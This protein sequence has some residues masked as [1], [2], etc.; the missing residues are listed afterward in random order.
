[1]SG[2]VAR[3]APVRPEPS[4]AAM[5]DA[6]RCAAAAAE[7]A[8]RGSESQRADALLDEEVARAVEAARS[9]LEACEAT[10]VEAQRRLLRLIPYHLAAVRQRVSDT[11]QGSPLAQLA[12]DAR[13]AAA[14]V[15][16][17]RPPSQSSVTAGLL[18][19]L[20]P[21][22]GTIA[23]PPPVAGLHPGTINAAR[24]WLSA[25]AA[26]G[27]RCAVSAALLPRRVTALT[28]ASTLVRSESHTAIAVDR[29]SDPSRVYP[30]VG[31][32]IEV[33]G[34]NRPVQAFGIVTLRPERHAE[35]LSPH[36]L[37]PD[38][39][40]T[41]A[42][43][44]VVP[45][46]RLAVWDA[47][48]AT[49]LLANVQPGRDPQAQLVEEFLDTRV[50][51]RR[52]Q[53]YAPLL[54]PAAR[55]PA[56]YAGAGGVSAEDEAAGGAQEVLEEPPE[57][58]AEQAGAE[59]YSLNALIV[60]DHWQGDSPD[61]P[62]PCRRAREAASAAINAVA[63]PL[64]EAAEQRLAAAFASVRG[65]PVP[66][67]ILREVENAHADIAAVAPARNC[68]LPPSLRQLTLPADRAPAP[69]ERN[70]AGL[71]PFEAALQQLP[72]DADIR[73][74]HEQIVA[75]DPSI[76]ADM[77]T[78]MCWLAPLRSAF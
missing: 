62:A 15:A 37:L 3:S 77:S 72:A 5:R 31:R 48:T 39:T 67:D 24:G 52:G 23:V 76:A 30:C 55:I 32:G 49:W 4:V 35:M 68:M 43:G 36:V 46:W 66:E 8:A 59:P 60:R 64:K 75:N 2:G 26:S 33:P 50:E 11:D 22:E 69:V 9:L 45:R 19:G 29:Y 7:R 13:L 47:S 51:V 17:G 78:G 27:M 20:H 38:G 70:A 16:A 54:A 71:L 74:A 1:M 6:L 73:L 44:R 63:Q 57:E 34:L 53:L 10:G 61:A 41:A 56:R 40:A 58:E 18:G 14:N 12:A 28:R 21:R 25:L 65:R 42:D